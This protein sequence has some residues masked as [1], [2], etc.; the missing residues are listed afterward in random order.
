MG[1]R[2]S[3]NIGLREMEEG[4]G[5]GRESRVCGNSHPKERSGK[6]KAEKWDFLAGPVG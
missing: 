1:I 3:T 6:I 2:E 4:S 5:M